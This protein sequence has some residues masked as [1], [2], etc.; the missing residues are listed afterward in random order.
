MDRSII[1]SPSLEV[2]YYVDYEK[3]DGKVRFGDFRTNLQLYE[4]PILNFNEE[5]DNL[6]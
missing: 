3:S 2:F 5:S 6:F 4:S 1:G